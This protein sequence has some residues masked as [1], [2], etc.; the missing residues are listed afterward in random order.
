MIQR[1]DRSAPEAQSVSSRAVLNFLQE[2]NKN[3]RIHS[4]MLVKNGKVIC[5]RWWKPYAPQYRH[6]LYSL[7]K[8]FTSIAAGIA[9]DEGLLTLDT[10]ICD[11]FADEMK[12]LENRTDE[13]MKKM[14]VRHLLSMSVGTN[15]ENWQWDGEHMTNIVGF[16]KTHLQYEPG[17]KF[18]YHT[19]ATYMC[20]AAITRLT[21]QKLTEWLKPRLFEPLG[22]IEPYWVEDELAG[23]DFGGF[24]LN[25]RTED[26]AVFGQ[27]LLQKGMWN[28]KR[29]VSEEYINLA[30]SKQ[31][32]NGDDPAND[33]AQG[34]GFQFWRCVPEGVYR[35]DGMHGQYCVVC[36]DMQT[37]IAVT[38]NAD[39]GAVMKLFW[40]MLEE[41]KEFPLNDG[42]F[43]ELQAYDGFTHLAVNEGQ[44]D[45]P[46]FRGEY[47]FAEMNND[48]PKL[49]SVYFDN[50][51]YECVI[52]FYNEAKKPATGSF[53]ARKGEWTFTSA[54]Y[55]GFGRRKTARMMSY[56][57][58]QN[59]VL[60]AAAWHF[61]IPERDDFRFTFSADKSEVL[62]EH[63]GGAFNSEFKTVGKAVR[64]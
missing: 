18:H 13:R 5:E 50:C 52:I 30:T 29:I 63:K 58:W 14:T 12:N 57:E 41:M 23:V 11:I 36:P 49:Y 54:P 64:R 20:S 2:A 3:H 62:V 16:L 60:N 35:G 37:V 34:Y 17:E 48:E 47:V 1:L 8:S 40:K 9:I 31:I 15:H 7:S 44:G 43:E 42:D 45:Y 38:S 55:G 46:I 19:L 51:L 61:E 24:G 21:G 22:I 6:E 26:I 59:D 53:V 28:G 25:V 10:L 39:M 32:E 33:W 56:A 4:F 27:M